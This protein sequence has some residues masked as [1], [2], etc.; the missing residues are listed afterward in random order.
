[1]PEDIVDEL[2]A[3]GDPLSVRAARY[4]RI[5]RSTEDGLRTELRR[6][7]QRLFE[8]PEWSRVHPTGE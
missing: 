6:V 1:V 4:I 3:R 8:C 5:K 2:E 7:C